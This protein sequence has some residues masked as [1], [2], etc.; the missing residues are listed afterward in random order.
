MNL[1]EKITK[2]RKEKSLSQEAFA[3]KLGVSRQS[4][5][6]WE[7]G[8]ALPDTDKIVAMSELFGVTADY[9]LKDDYPE[10]QEHASDPEPI[11]EE[12]VSEEPTPPV[13]TDETVVYE[14]AAEP[15]NKKRKVFPKIIA[16]ILV[17]LIAASAMIIPTFS[18]KIKTKTLQFL[19][20]CGI[21][22]A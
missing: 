7:T 14:Q 1:S 2:L 19:I 17:V 10:E 21:S 3:E 13:N 15:K 6:K 18:D 20:A 4:V 9:L 5:S 8:S 16:I 11:Q 12:P 22:T